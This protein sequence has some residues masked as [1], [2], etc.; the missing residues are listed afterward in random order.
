ML[1]KM[2]NNPSTPVSS[3]PPLSFVPNSETP[4]N[5]Y[6]RPSQLEPNTVNLS[7]LNFQQIGSPTTTNNQ[8]PMAP[9]RIQ[10]MNN[11]HRN[12]GRTLYG[13]P[14]SNLVI[15]NQVNTPLNTLPSTFPRFNTPNTVTSIPQTPQNVNINRNLNSLFE[16]EN[17]TQQPV[18]QVT[19]T[20]TQERYFFDDFF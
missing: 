9:E 1:Y 16:Q 8:V 15:N 5:S 18:T 4:I 17:V 7:R 11:F 13:T 6:I 12:L 14:P 19:E 3:K 20:V 10:A 2:N